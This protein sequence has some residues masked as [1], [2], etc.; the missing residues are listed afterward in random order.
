MGDLCY[1]QE[2]VLPIPTRFISVKLINQNPLSISTLTRFL[3]PSIGFLRRL[4]FD[5]IQV[6]NDEEVKD[7]EKFF[8]GLGTTLTHLELGVFRKAD[9][10]TTLK[11]QSFLPFLPNLEQLHLKTG[12]NIDST[13]FLVISRLTR[14]IKLSILCCDA[15]LPQDS[16]WRLLEFIKNPPPALNTVQ[17]LLGE[18]PYDHSITMEM[19]QKIQLKDAA[20]A[21]NLEL[22]FPVEWVTTES[23]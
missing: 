13:I 2:P 5:Y 4:S 22:R 23:K 14:L 21:K 10:E 3:S 11:P 7:I 8:K 9:L 6:D 12:H 15:T 16:E 1:R 18:E 20:K 19:E 17:F